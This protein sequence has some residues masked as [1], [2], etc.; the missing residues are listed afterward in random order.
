MEKEKILINEEAQS[1]TKVEKEAVE[2]YYE[3]N[4]K[5]LENTHICTRRVKKTGYVLAKS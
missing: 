5:Y 2:E 4:N 1:E 3:K